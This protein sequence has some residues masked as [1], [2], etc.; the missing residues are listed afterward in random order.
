MNYE[1]YQAY[2]RDT[3]AENLDPDFQSYNNTANPHPKWGEYWFFLNH[4][5]NNAHTKADYSGIVSWRFGQKTGIAGRD[6][7]EF[8][9]QNPGPL[10][11]CR[12]TKG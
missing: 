7:I 6:F 12:T 11:G 2:Y 10:C 1:I 5:R 4:Y 8:I 9:R 3:Q